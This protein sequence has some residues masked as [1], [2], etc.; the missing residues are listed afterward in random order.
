MTFCDPAE[1]ELLAL[2]VDGVL[3]AGHA[4]ADDTGRTFYAFD[5]QDGSG[6]K[7][8]QRCGGKIALITG[9]QSP[10][11]EL[12]AETLGIEFV[13]QAALKKIEPFR[14]CLVDTGVDPQ[15]VCYV[16]DDLPDLPVIRHCGYPVAVANAVPEIKR[17][18]A[19]VT[20]RPGGAGAVREVIELLL[21]ARGQWDQIVQGYI[22]QK[23]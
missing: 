12:R 10:V 7:Y 5:T 13:Y 21:R 14:R 20:T 16:G 11:I 2:D 23:L 19:Y 18:A 17:A 15:R 22:D 6:I 1:I 8:W 9:R 4:I 3:T